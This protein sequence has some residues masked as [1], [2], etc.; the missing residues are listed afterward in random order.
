M[1]TEL[2][3]F[4]QGPQ[5]R[6]AANSDFQKVISTDLSFTTPEELFDSVRTQVAPI[7]C[8]GPFT[9]SRLRTMAALCGTTILNT[10]TFGEIRE[11]RVTPG[12]AT[13]SIAES[14]AGHPSHTDGTFMHVPPSRFFLYVE[15]QDGSGGGTSF[16]CRGID[17][18]AALDPEE[19]TALI[20]RDVRYA[21][22]DTRGFTDDWTGPLVG[23]GPHG[24]TLRWRDDYQVQPE[25][26]DPTDELHQRAINSLRQ[27]IAELP[28]IYYHAREGDLIVVPNTTPGCW[29]HGRTALSPDSKRCV[30]R[31][32][33]A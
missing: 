15:Q 4:N 17:A 5:A 27:R 6:L 20:K 11:I 22:R 21:R 19:L 30:L 14:Y 31:V 24:V 7:V 28:R 8:R 9:R 10:R 23:F 18:L 26:V 29:L 1:N 2:M 32:W 33:L 3:A 13:S 12:V 25:P 16:F